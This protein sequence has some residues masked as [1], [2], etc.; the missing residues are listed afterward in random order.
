MVVEVGLVAMF[1]GSSDVHFE[2]S[3]CVV[4][5]CKMCGG[6]PFVSVC[7]KRGMT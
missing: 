5:R 3:E 2:L 7:E 1:G 4:N 6:N